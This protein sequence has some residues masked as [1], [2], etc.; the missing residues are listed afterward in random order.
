MIVISETN[1]VGILAVVKMYSPA[2]KAENMI[3][4]EA[5]ARV[6]NWYRPNWPTW[7]H[8]KL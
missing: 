3:G 4:S 7:K 6:I 2:A 5:K 1:L 8:A